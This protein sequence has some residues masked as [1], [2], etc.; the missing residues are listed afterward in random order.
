[1]AGNMKHFEDV[2]LNEDKWVG[3]VGKILVICQG[4]LLFSDFPK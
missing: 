4:R 1:M 2:F 3:M